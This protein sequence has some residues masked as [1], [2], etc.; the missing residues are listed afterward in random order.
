MDG[1]DAGGKETKSGKSL[2]SPLY[3]VYFLTVFGALEASVHQY[4]ETRG[5][6]EVKRAMFSLP[7]PKGR[8]LFSV[9]LLC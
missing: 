5:K 9:C 3:K 2:I 7:V 8:Q 6:L 1:E 4:S